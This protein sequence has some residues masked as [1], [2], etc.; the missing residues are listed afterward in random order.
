MRRRWSDQRGQAT[1]ELALVLPVVVIV[2]LLVLQVG[3]TVRDRLVAVHAVRAAARAVIVEPTEAAARTALGGTGVG[4][5]GRVVVGGDL[6]PGGFATVT[7]TL[8][9]TRVPIVGRVLGASRV[10]ERLVVQVEG[11]G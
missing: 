4:G 9:P 1:V 11:A 6:R 8:Q 10:T 5:R 3:L 7:V 2:M